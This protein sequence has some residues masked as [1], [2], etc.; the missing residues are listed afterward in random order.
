MTELSSQRVEA[1]PL[2]PL[3]SVVLFPHTEVPLYIFEP[4]YR[5]MTQAALTGG[6]HIG[7]VTVVPGQLDQMS[8]NPDIFSVGCAGKI[9]SAKERPDGSFEI[10]LAG[11]Y[12]FRIER[13]TAPSDG[14]TFREADITVLDD[15]ADASS[16][17]NISQFRSEVHARYGRLLE[18]TAPQYVDRFN[19]QQFATVPDDV[20][21]NT[22]S[23][24][25]DIDAVEKQSLLECSWAGSRLELLRTILDFKLAE[26]GSSG[27]SNPTSLQ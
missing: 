18:K 4:R 21:V 26:A 13:E 8:G 23:L 25:L 10:V 1:L 24:S 27:P 9:K 11:V 5:L 2:F 7:M 14:T 12:R 16:N 17:F 20:Y 6:K 3:A 15:S 19:A 22:V